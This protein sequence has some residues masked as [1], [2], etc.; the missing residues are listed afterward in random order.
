MKRIAF[1]L[2]FF[3]A[4]G[5]WAQAERMTDINTAHTGAAATGDLIGDFIYG[6]EMLTVGDRVWFTADDGIH[7]VELWSTD[8]SE[9]GTTRATDL[10]PGRCSSHPLF[11]TGL[12]GRLLFLADDGV[13][14]SEPWIS[15]GTAPGTRLLADL[16]PG[17]DDGGDFGWIVAANGHALVGGRTVDGGAQIWVVDGL[18]AS[19]RLLRQ[20]PAAP[21]SLALGVGALGDL[22]FFV[23]DDGVHG[24]ELWRSDGT[25]AGTF[26]LET[27]P[28]GSGAVIDRFPSRRTAATSSLL[29]FP[30][31]DGAHGI[32][33]WCTDGTVAGTRPVRDIHPGSLGGDPQWLVA[34]DD[35]VFFAANDGVHGFELWQSDGTEAGTTLVADLA[36]GADSG[37]PLSFTVSA[38]RLF[39]RA[40]ST[41]LRRWDLWV[42]DGS[43]AGTRI[44]RAGLRTAGL[45][46][47]VAAGQGVVFHAEQA[48]TGLEP[49]YSDGTETGTRQLADLVPGSESSFLETDDVRGQRRAS[50]AGRAYFWSYSPGSDFELWSSDGTSTGT[51]LVKDI[52]AQASS[53]LVKPFFYYPQLSIYSPIAP[54]ATPSGLAF[55]ATDGSL[56][57]AHP[58]AGTAGLEPW[59]VVHESGKVFSLGDLTPGPGASL[60]PSMVQTDSQVVFTDVQNRV[61]SSTGD[62]ASTAL[63]AG[64]PVAALLARLPGTIVTAGS[65]SNSSGIV[66]TALALDLS[67]VTELPLSANW[68]QLQTEGSRAV[69]SRFDGMALAETNGTP[70]GTR[71]VA[72]GTEPAFAPSA[73]PSGD[74]VFLR[75]QP[76]SGLEPWVWTGEKLQILADIFPGPGSPFS[77]REPLNVEWEWSRPRFYGAGPTAFFAADDGTHGQELWATDGTTPG[78]RLVA[79]IFPGPR[80][81]DL[82]RLTPVGSRVY[83]VADDGVHG[84]ELWLSDGTAAGTRLLRDLA[85]GPGS[86][87]PQELTAI[88][89]FLVFNAW[90]PEHGRELWISDGT[91][92]GTRR[93]TDVAPGPLSSSPVTYVAAGGWLYFTANDNLTGD[94]LWR[95]PLAQIQSGSIFADGF[96]SGTLSA[97]S[98][99]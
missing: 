52:N 74:V 85:P 1:G 26:V 54:V 84:R 27:N 12:D 90:T 8:G 18:T 76:K 43:A 79:E 64:A 62:P 14:G 20:F 87:V 40:W 63:V 66:P 33:L 67:T 71:Q 61:W 21:T 15:D 83:F 25:D 70:E 51:R 99:P 31:A 10:C 47:P 89:G 37:S 69:F 19:T 4:L 97:W 3:A 36:T 81:A 68:D 6:R 22:T 17:L 42:T 50:L 55:L 92:I 65:E 95:L 7:G 93:L 34:W 82:R 78:T 72:L 32:E 49:W 53:R 57:P 29:F 80:G 11:L 73:L 28:T 48:D 35:R 56:D 94:E 30:G 38:G 23:L 13:H 9:A 16:R 91:E 60:T 45:P 46:D 2:L 88:G 75:H 59:H 5:A 24:Y 44:L 41:D 98:S 58:V 77:P 86:A 39:F 96:E